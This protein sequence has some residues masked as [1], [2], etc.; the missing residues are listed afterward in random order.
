MERDAERGVDWVHLPVIATVAR[1]LLDLVYY[2]LRKGQDYRAPKPRAAATADQG[3][4]S[5]TL[6]GRSQR[7][8]LTWEAPEIDD[9]MRDVSADRDL[10]LQRPLHRLGEH[11]RRGH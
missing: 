6:S 1:R 4:L 8:H 9:S 7:P 10:S 3:A 5:R 11:I 2:L